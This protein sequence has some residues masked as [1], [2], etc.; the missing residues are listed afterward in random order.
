MVT[1]ISQANK[2]EK[3]H[4]H[5]QQEPYALYRPED[6]LLYSYIHATLLVQLEK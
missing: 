4:L 3:E 2:T 6:L 1:K 5:L